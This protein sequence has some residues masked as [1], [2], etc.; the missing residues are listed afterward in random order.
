MTDLDI[1]ALKAAAL[2][3][4]GNRLYLDVLLEMLD[5]AAVLGL[6]ERL[7]R[8][9]ARADGME[10]AGAEQARRADENAEVIRQQ[11][12]RLEKLEA[13]AKAAR[14]YKDNFYDDVAGKLFAMLEQ[15]LAA[16]E[17]AP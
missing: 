6:I 5:P 13:V 1:P 11:R 8:A 3:A 15:A 9:E 2:A 10:R 14:D 7:E 16:L 12:A 17:A 4:K